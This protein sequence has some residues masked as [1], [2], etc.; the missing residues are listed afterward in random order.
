VVAVGV[1][2]GILL[3][4]VLSLIRIVRH[5]YRPHTGVIQLDNGR[6]WRVA[7]VAAGVVTE[8]GL[9]LY[10]FG[11]SLFYANANRFAEELL[12]LAGSPPS[13]VRWIIVDA[14][15][16]PQIDYSASRVIAQLNDEL[17]R[18][19]VTLGFARMPPDAL[20]DFHR[21]HLAERIPPSR[22]FAR[23]HDALSAFQQSAPQ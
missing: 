6:S 14:E 3:A 13:A 12:R 2:A 9:V 16:I 18:I 23:L 17:N 4:M 15:A 1:E 10:R 5:S 22:V 19:G 8:P 20:A 21:H 7:P 11:A